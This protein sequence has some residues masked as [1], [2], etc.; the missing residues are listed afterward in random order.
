MAEAVH[1]PRSEENQELTEAEI[2]MDDSLKDL[3]FFFGGWGGGEGH[4]AILQ[5]FVEVELHHFLWEAWGR[6]FFEVMWETWGY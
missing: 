5:L 3:L 1:P 2:E 6:G 4:S